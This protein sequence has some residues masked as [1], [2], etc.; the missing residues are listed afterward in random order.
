[1]LE[2]IAAIEEY[3]AQGRAAFLSDRRTRH[4]VER[5]LTIIGEAVKGL[6]Q[7]FREEHPDV[8]WRR[9]AGLR[10]KLIH[11][12]PGVEAEIVWTIVERHLP[13]LRKVLERARTEF[14]GR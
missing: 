5:N 8:E 13:A 3:T 6:S 12:Y 9:V 7:T 11:D 1:M 2:A 14:A 4:A 10:D